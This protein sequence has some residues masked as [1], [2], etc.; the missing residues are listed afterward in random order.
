VVLALAPL[1]PLA[2]VA[3]AYRPSVEPAGEL[4]MA[5]PAAGLRV[6]AVRALV[7]ALPAVPLAVGGALLVGLPLGVALGWLLPGAALAGIVLL[8]G[9]TRL[10][11]AVV[12]TV[13]GATW[14]VAVSWPPAARRV[15]ADAVVDL[16][17]SAPAQLTA[18]AVALA[19][20]SLAVARRDAVSY[21]RTA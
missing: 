18:L 14:A 10:D 15:A 6:V 9:T 20:V 16:V 7:V 4:A 11:P 17:A 19:A 21:R 13:L 1:A 2:A 3:L 5:T 8:A 12:A